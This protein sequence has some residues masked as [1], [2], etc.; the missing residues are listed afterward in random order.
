MYF[1]GGKF[2]LKI[3]GSVCKSCVRS[4]MLFGSETWCLGQNE[5]GILQ[6]TEGAIVRCMCGV[7]L[8]DMKSTKDSVQMLNLNLT[9]DQLA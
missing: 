1:V 4:A 7:N 8:M 9:I 5:M 2:P 3:K 6:R